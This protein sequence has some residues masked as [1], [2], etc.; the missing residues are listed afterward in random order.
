MRWTLDGG[1]VCR[2]HEKVCLTG[3]ERKLLLVLADRPQTLIDPRTL[4]RRV[5]VTGGTS[6]L[7]NVV[8]RLR[9]KIEPDPSEPRWLV[10]VRGQGYRLDAAPAPLPGTLEA[11]RAT[12]RAMVVFAT[13]GG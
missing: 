9:S 3:L 7:A 2:G 13:L 8:Y 10:A 11:M 12:L 1:F 4:A 5:G 6:A